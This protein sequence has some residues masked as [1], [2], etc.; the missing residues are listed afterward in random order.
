MLVSG[1]YQSDLDIYIYIKVIIR[2]IRVYILIFIAALFTIAKTWKR[3]KCPLTDEWME[4]LWYIYK[5]EYYSVIENEIMPFA[6]TWMD[7][8]NLLSEVNQ[9]K[10]NIVASLM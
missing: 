9:R 4:K 1:V 6:A 3:P 2:Y 8:E 10:R 7:L 5:V